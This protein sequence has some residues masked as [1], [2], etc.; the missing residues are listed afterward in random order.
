MIETAN[1]KHIKE[2]S[3]AA[4]IDYQFVSFDLLTYIYS[5][6]TFYVPINILFSLII[7]HKYAPLNRLRTLLTYMLTSDLLTYL[8]TQ[9]RD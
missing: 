8:N 9:H 2:K 6:F 5:N 4:L 1:L 3:K 7:L